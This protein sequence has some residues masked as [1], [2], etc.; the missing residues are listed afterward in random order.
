MKGDGN[1]KIYVD[2]NA[3]QDYTTKLIAK[4]KT[5]F[6]TK[7]DVGSPLVASTVAEMT[8]HDKV[9][10]YVGSETGYTSGNWYYWDG[11][12]WTS[13]GVYNSE[14]FV[15]DDTLTSATLPAQAKAVGDKVSQLSEELAIEATGGKTF[16]QA[17]IIQG[18]YN[19]SGAVT[20]NA[21]RIRTEG[22]IPVYKGEK[23]SFTPG[24]N[25]KQIIYGKFNTSKTFVQ[26]GPWTSNG[27]IDVDWDG[28]LILAWRKSSDNENIT[29]SD[30]DATTVL[31]A[32]DAYNINWNRNALYT[33]VGGITNTF[34][35]TAQGSAKFKIELLKGL[36][37]TYKNNTT[38]SQTLNL[39]KDDGT[40]KSL[41]SSLSAGAS[42]TFVPESNDYTAIGGFYNNAGTGILSCD[43]LSPKVAELDDVIN[44]YAETGKSNVSVGAF[45]QGT[46]G[47]GNG[48]TVSAN[49]AIRT[50]W[51]E[52]Q[53]LKYDFNIES[54]YKYAVLT[55]NSTKTFIVSS[56]YKTSAYVLDN[57]DG[58]AKYIRIKIAK[59]DGTDIAP[60]DAPDFAMNRIFKNTTDIARIFDMLGNEVPPEYWITYLDN[61]IESINSTIGDVGFK[62]D[63]FFFFT[64]VH[65][66][67][68]EK[69]SP[70]I[71]KYL[72][73]KTPTERVIQGGDI[74]N[75]HS[76][77]AAALQILED[78]MEQTNGLNV[79]NLVGNHDDNSNGQTSETTRFVGAGTFYRLL[80]SRTESF[81]SWAAGKNYG[82][83]D[84]AVQKIRHIYLDTGTPDMHQIEQDQLD[85]FS[86]RLTELAT[87]WTVVVFAHMLFTPRTSEYDSLVMNSNG[88]AVAGVI[89]NVLDAANHPH[90]ACVISGH[91]HRDYSIA[92]PYE[93][94]Y[95]IICTTCDA[96]STSEDP[97]SEY[98]AGTTT[99]QAIDIFCINTT[100]KTINAIRIGDGQDRD[101]TYTN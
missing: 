77:R 55:Y 42:Y 21:A 59:T 44:E 96:G 100:D 39:Y 89:D 5:I 54:G 51:I 1:L 66:P 72:K 12:A 2:K 32:K 31:I 94:N 62:G 15:L 6:A 63:S 56:Y 7:N 33:A 71:I 40:S 17:D 10:V 79:I 101:W 93:H 43:G 67:S 47:D 92:D 75:K 41:V 88:W 78:Y 13:G 26:D 83:Y 99:A 49:D 34:I 52:I 35:I 86:A 61:K 23:I 20:T 87:D 53:N 98:V 82:Y 69:N 38:A 9:Y 29:P 27:V 14:G 97:N 84:N 18:S 80:N 19:A 24:T 22:F 57:R 37:Y 65:W 50:D 64:D 60:V 91:T 76:S 4:E 8:D 81:V 73:H 30:Y 36:T 85:W 90:V 70:A 28:F 45:A 58:A 46:I 48:A 25:I 3:L 95:P 11:T 68:N 74:L 16:T